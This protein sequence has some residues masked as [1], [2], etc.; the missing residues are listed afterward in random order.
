MS[1]VNETA[2]EDINKVVLDVANHVEA[3][4]SQSDIVATHR[5]G[6]DS[7]NDLGAARCVI[8]KNKCRDIIVKFSNYDARYRMLKGRVKLRD[9]HS[10]VF[11]NEELTRNRRM[12]AYESRQ[13]KKKDLIKKTWVYK[14]NVYILDKSDNKLCVW[15]LDDLSP[16]KPKYKCP[17]SHSIRYN[18]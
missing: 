8:G 9:A 17:L 14:G 11:I 12:L 3:V 18:H 15:C 13:L 5:L 10:K 7:S 1:G 6:I 16:T 2:N 4:I